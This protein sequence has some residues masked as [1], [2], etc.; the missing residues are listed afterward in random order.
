MSSRSTRTSLVFVCALCAHALG[1]PRSDPTSGRAVFTGAATP[2]ATSIDVNPAALGLGVSSELYVA[3]VGALNRYAI[4]RD[5]IDVDTGIVSGGP[6]PVTAYTSSPGVTLAGVYHTGTDSRITLA[7]QFKTAPAERFLEHE[8]FRYHTLGGYHRTASLTFGASVRLTR[9][10]YIGV[11]IAAQSNFLRLRYARD[12]ALEDAR[13]PDRGIDSDC[14]GAR[15]GVENPLADERYEIAT[16]SGLFSTSIIAVNLGTT[17]R[18]A[19]DTWLGIGYHAPPG[20]AIQNELTGEMYVTRAPRDGADAIT[21]AATVYISQP[22]SVDVELTTP[23]VEHVNV[24]VGGRWEHLSRFESY[25]VRGYGST[26][27]PNNI[28][29]WQPRPRGFHDTF[30]LWA[31]VEQTGFDRDLALGARIGVET[32][33]LDDDRTSPLTI[34]PS[35]GTLDFGIQYQLTPTLLVQA[36]YGLQYFPTVEVTASEFDPRARLSC[37]DSGYDYSTPGCA[38]VRGGYAIPTALGDYQRIEQAMR[39]AVRWVLE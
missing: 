11:S 36:S 23:L 9:R 22:A 31:G 33:A 21:G 10:V 13:D 2:S 15:C 38:R 32:S 18:I 28:P 34:A 30:A 37:I 1:S 20:L 27:P 8:A 16:D 7:L 17:I 35:S 12:T 26:L 4:D 39:L 24:H 25:D 6:A 3:L 19:Q 14:G 5:A 29:E